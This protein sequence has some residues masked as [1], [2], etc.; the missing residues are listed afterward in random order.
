M[1]LTGNALY[2]TGTTHICHKTKPA[3]EVSIAQDGSSSG[4]GSMTSGPGSTGSRAGSGD[5][6]DGPGESRSG[7]GSGDGNL[8]SGSVLGPLLARAGRGTGGGFSSSG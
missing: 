2:R 6:G 5:T 7:S 1:F 8:G 4:L 3:A